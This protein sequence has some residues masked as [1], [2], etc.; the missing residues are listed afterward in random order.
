M[1]WMTR[2]FV[3]SLMPKNRAERSMRQAL[4]WTR[5]GRPSGV[6]LGVLL[7]TLVLVG[8]VRPSA[9]TSDE[10]FQVWSPVYLTV[11]FTDKVLGWYEAQ[12]RFGEDASRLNQLLL[13]T[14]LGYR[15]APRWSLW[16]GYAWTPS[17]EPRFNSENR[18]YQQLLYVTELSF[19]RVMSRTRFEQRWIE[20]V[21]GTAFRFRTLLRGRFPL[22]EDGGWGAVA[23]DE[24]FLNLNSPTNGP[25][26]GFDQNRFFLGLN[27]RVNTHLSVDVGYQLQVVDTEEPGF[28]DNL[29]HILLI[30]FFLN[31]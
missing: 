21:T 5:R 30:Q 1:E 17:F 22:T 4:E 14:A 7:A 24:I 19:A 16:L 31:V 9:A 18:M 20:G 27:R 10:D 26:A 23:Q 15:F 3:V 12:P 13:R 28:P 25:S 8:A 29:N 6:K 11:S 2:G